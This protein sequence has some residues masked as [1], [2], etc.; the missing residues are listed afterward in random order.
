MGGA[1]PADFV[2]FV[3][4]YDR[5]LTTACQEITGHD[6][7]AEVLRL[8]LLATVALRWRH[9]PSGRRPRR[10]VARLNRLLRREVRSY[11]L[12]PA[13]P[14][15]PSRT[16]LSY[17]DSTVDPPAPAPSLVDSLVGDSLAESAWRRA[18][19]LRRQALAGLAAAVAAIAVLAL[20]GPQ[21]RTPPAPVLPPDVEIPAGVVVL[22]RF[23]ALGQL[24]Q[25]S[26]PLPAE[27]TPAGS[28]APATRALALVRAEHGPLVVIGADGRTRL[29]D[30]PALAAA[31]LIST[32]LA[33]DGDLAVLVVGDALLVVDLAT[34]QTRLIA[35]GAAAPVLVWRTRHS[36]LVPGPDHAREIDLDTGAA[37]PVVGVTGVDVVSPE[38]RRDAPLTEL[39]AVSST[40]GQASRIRL[41]RT[42]PGLLSTR[43]VEDR[44]TF[45]P[46]WIGVWSGPGWSSPTLFARACAPGEITLPTRFGPARSAIG[47]LGINGIYAGTLVAVDN[48]TLE[49]LGFLQSQT[50][51]VAAHGPTSTRL[52]AWT[53]AAATVATVAATTAPATITLSDLLPPS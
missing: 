53:P 44:P 7:L 47:A 3:A 39:L 51:L 50:I 11:R 36:V 6:R 9:S 14:G 35:A 33:P 8:D 52:I 20:I 31:R 24:P 37:T 40:A 42:A 17:L 13:P 22:P 19:Q 5:P 45:G 1:A 27:L 25:A 15:V 48:T 28:D 21:A 32:S 26:T 34:S 18:G 38:G 49:P 10:A 12:V 23:E 41:W 4:T 16:S 43:D 2:S 46:Q 29:I 30:D